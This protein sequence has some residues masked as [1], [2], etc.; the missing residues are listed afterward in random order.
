MKNLTINKIYDIINYK[1]SEDCNMT[2]EEKRLKDLFI[3]GSTIIYHEKPVTIVSCD[4]P[5]YSNLYSS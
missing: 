1:E 3:P 4:K 5:I 2:A